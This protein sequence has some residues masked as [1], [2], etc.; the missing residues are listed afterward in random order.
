LINVYVKTGTLKGNSVISLILTSQKYKW[1]KA[2]KVKKDLPQNSFTKSVVLDALGLL[3]A[4]KH[5]KDRYRKKKVVV[6]DDSS[7]IINALKQTEEGIFINKTKIEI[8]DNL[9]D[10]VGTFNDLSLKKFNE[11]CEYKEELEHIFI[12]CALD[13][14]EIDEKD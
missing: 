1:T 10:S 4:I 8:V 3:Y 12:E 9:R 7:H 11:E 5:I 2:F 14:I 13:H 6:Y